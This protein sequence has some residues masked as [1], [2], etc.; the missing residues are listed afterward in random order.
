[1]SVAAAIL[2]TARFAEGGRFNLPFQEAL[3]YLRQKVSLPS[4]TY[5]ALIGRAHDRG[6]V[7]AGATKEALIEDIRAAVD[8]AIEQGWTPRQFHERFEE[9]VAQHGW[10]DW[11]GEDTPE[12]RAWRARIIYGTNLRSS[13]A[14]GRWKQMT[15]PDLVKVRPYWQY[16]HAFTRIPLRPRPDH[17]LLD[18]LILAWNDRWWLRY[19]PPNDYECS[20]G[21]ATLSMSDMKRLGKTGPDPTPTIETYKAKDPLT[22]EWYDQPEGIAPGWDHAPGRDWVEGLVPPE[23]Q[24]PLAPLADDANRSAKIT[25][26]PLPEA[27]AFKAGLLPTGQDA[28]SYVSSFLKGFGASL[29]QS[30]AWRDP[31]GHV[32]AISDALFKTANGAWKVLKRGRETEV[33]RLAETLQDPDEIWVDWYR[34]QDG[35]PVLTRSY[36]RRAAET[37]GYG[38]FQWSRKGWSGVTAFGADSEAYLNNQRRGA[39]LWQRKK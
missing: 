35:Q 34:G 1:M 38:L 9:I 10:T 25:L 5:R 13:Y 11:T 4:K 36:I 29:G 15:D 16:R 18:M 17:V 27:R 37:N 6:F 23:L 28:A 26:P 19:Y 31:A 2:G 20:C 3:D 30:V 32:L 14:A 8:R 7:V 22:G 12:G 39:L 24:Q 21:V 33:E